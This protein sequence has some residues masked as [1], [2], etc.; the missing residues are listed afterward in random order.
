MIEVHNEPVKAL[1]DSGQ[2]LTPEQFH[3]LIKRLTLKKE[4]TNSKDY[5]T[6]ISELRLEVD[7]IDD[8]LI[9]LLGKRMK[10]AEKMGTLKR[11]NNISILQPQRWEEIIASR[12]AAGSEQQ[13]SK[14][15]IFQLIQAIHEEAIRQQE[16][17]I[18]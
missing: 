14:E 18:E 10:I 6:R 16:K 12:L 3:S 9:K 13:L 7:T 5:R 4:S 15:F 17:D 1:S 2:Q 8:H 11:K